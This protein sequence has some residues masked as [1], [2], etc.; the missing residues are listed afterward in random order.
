M[1]Y[2]DASH[3][4]EW[5]SRDGNRASRSR[6]P[7]IKA[8]DQKRASGR[9]PTCSRGKP[10]LPTRQNVGSFDANRIADKKIEINQK[11]TG[12]ER[13]YGAHGRDLRSVDAR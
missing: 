8:N 4:D 9:V 6:P 12:P 5:I 7:S 3:D 10:D 11:L 2:W 1:T 13:S